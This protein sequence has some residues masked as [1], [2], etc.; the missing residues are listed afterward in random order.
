[1]LGPGHYQ[2]LTQ[3]QAKWNRG[4]HVGTWSLLAADSVVGKVEPG[5]PCWNLVTT[6]CRLSS[7]QSE[8]RTA[9]LEPGHYQLLTQQQAKW[10]QG[11]HVGTW[12]LLAADS[13]VGKVE[14]GQL[15]WNL[16]T[17]KTVATDS[18][19]SKVKPRTAILE[20]GHYQLQT[21]QQAEQNRGGHIGTWSL[22]AAD[23][24]PEVAKIEAG[25]P[26]WSLVTTISADSTVC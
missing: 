25:Q 20:T 13:V 1:M 6:S 22:L 12:S 4:S 10:N 3:Q 14:P 9:M 11:S 24:V 19:V 23:S 18:V 15:W 17:K 5:Q 21:Q 8:T 7:R 2:L 26:Y 16:D